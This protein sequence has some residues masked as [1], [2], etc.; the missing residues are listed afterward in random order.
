MKEENDKSRENRILDLIDSLLEELAPDDEMKVE[1]K[2]LS[3]CRKIST[4]AQNI[5]EQNG[6]M[7]GVS[8]EDKKK[9]IKS[10]KPVL[11]TLE[12]IE[13]GGEIDVSEYSD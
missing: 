7:S 10:L 4:T 5:I 3:L 6:F 9:I 11:M 8:V 12:A 13:E 1:A 2:L